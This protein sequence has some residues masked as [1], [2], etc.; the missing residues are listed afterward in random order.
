MKSKESSIIKNEDTIEGRKNDKVEVTDFSVK[1]VKP[2]P[3]EQVLISITVKNV[4]GRTLN[5]IP[6]QIGKDKEILYS[7]ERYNL[8][9]GKSF[10][11]S[12]SWTSVTGTHFFFGDVDPRNILKEPRT[13][14]FNNFPQGVDVIVSKT[15]K[16]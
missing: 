4:S 14:Q 6:W 11:V 3:G 12:V 9:T 7:G 13:K 8:P 16:P 15:K 2:K 10:K 1:P 5:E